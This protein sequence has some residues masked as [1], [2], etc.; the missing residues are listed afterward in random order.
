M[1]FDL[2]SVCYNVIF[3]LSCYGVLFM[4]EQSKQVKWI[5]SIDYARVVIHVDGSCSCRVNV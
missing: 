1:T 5:R 2:L 3:L 4:S